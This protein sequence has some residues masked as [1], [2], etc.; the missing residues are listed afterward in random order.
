MED[1]EE[2]MPKTLAMGLIAVAMFAGSAEAR[3]GGVANPHKYLQRC[4]EGMVKATCACRA[5]K[6]H[7]YQVCGP[8]QWCHAFQGV[9]RQ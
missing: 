6:S 7:H 5:E 8:G 2:S 4:A 9:C 1:R 3:I